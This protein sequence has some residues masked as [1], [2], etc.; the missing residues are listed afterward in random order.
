MGSAD[1]DHQQILITL[2]PEPVNM[3]KEEVFR[4][5]GTTFLSLL[6]PLTFLLLARLCAAGYFLAVSDNGVLIQL[7][8]LTLSLL[9]S[10]ISIAA[11]L[12][13]LQ[14][15][16]RFRAA[17]IL[18]FLMQLSLA[19]GI[20]A[21]A[22]VDS[23]AGINSHTVGRLVLPRRAAFVFG[24]HEVM[25]F[26]SR[27]TVKPVV[28]KVIFGETRTRRRAW[29]CRLE[30]IAMAAGL[31]NLWWSKLGEEAEA[32]VVVPW[33]KWHLG[34][35]LTPPDVLAC[36]SYYL[37]AALGLLRAALL[38]WTLSS[39]VAGIRASAGG[40]RHAT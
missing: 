33:V 15:S 30:K 21:T 22:G 38:L 40:P 34:M 37:T 26:W 10:L 2:P 27:T 5:V 19:L 36:L 4:I 12:L 20:L 31:A 7:A 17:C 24:L 8:S 28:D 13:H 35:D 29:T 16:I 32:L 18:L 25:L 3:V 9:A 1:D 39:A 23:G 11:L 6:L 14:L